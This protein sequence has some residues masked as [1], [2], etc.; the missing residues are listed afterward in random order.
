MSFQRSH[1]KLR[2]EPERADQLS[3]GIPAREPVEQPGDRVAGGRFAPGN[4]GLSSRGGATRRLA[5]KM[6]VRIPVR[7]HLVLTRKRRVTSV[8]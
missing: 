5:A 3:D 2:A 7:S 8:G 4:K 1:G 6:A